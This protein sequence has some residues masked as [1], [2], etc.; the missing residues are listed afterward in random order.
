MSQE[1]RLHALDAARAFALLLGIVLHATMSFFFFV[2]AQD[3]SQSTTLAVTFYVIHV[4]R[5]GLFFLLAGFFA[6]MVLHRRGTREFLKGRAKRILVPMIVGWVLIA[7]PTIYIVIVGLTKTFGEQAAAS[8]AAMMPQGFPLTHLWFLYYLCIFYVLA[9]GVRAAFVRFVDPNGVVRSRIDTVVRLS[10][11]SYLA[12]LVLA[13]P[14][15]AVLYKDAAW[16]MWFGLPTPDIGFTPKLPALAGFGTAFVLGWLLHRQ[17]EVLEVF[18]RQCFVNLAVAIGLTSLCLSLVGLKPNMM[19]L[20]TLDGPAWSRAAYAGAYTV[21]IWYWVFGLTGAALR[22]FNKPSPGRRYIA[23]SSYWLY[24]AHLPVVFGLQV[25]L[26]DLPWHWSLKFPFIVVTTLAILLVSYHYLVRPT[27][28][29]GILNGRKYPRRSRRTGSD[30]A[31]APSASVLALHDTKPAVLEN[32]TRRFGKTVAL[33]DVTLTV[34]P[35][36]MLA[37]LGPNGAGKS[38]AISLWLGL[39]EPDEGSVRVMGASPLEVTSRLEVGVMMQDVNL[40]PDLKVREHIAQTASYYAHPLNVDEALAISGTTPLA[41]KRYGKL[42]G[43]QKRQV[44]FAVAIC[45]APKLLFLDEPTVG[46]DIEAREAMWRAIAKLMAEGSSIVLTTHYLEEAEALADR[47]A[48]LAKGK[49]VATGSVEDMR[50][51]VTRRRIS[52][53]SGVDIDEIRGWPGVVEALRDAGNVKVTAFDAESIVRRLLVADP[54]LSH[55]EVRQASLAEAF[56]ELTK[57]AA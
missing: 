7:P 25:L 48:V 3:P 37:V 54:A 16:M 13:A 34:E 26:L 43:G 41:G 28:I 17:V 20:T 55:L 40:A 31:P 49:L 35:G 22:F 8:G 57:E 23:D 29:G 51:L 5:M 50:S 24:L 4:F 39:L 14:L 47:V 11:A 10:L 56:T 9:L 1:N 2:P 36:E 32:V 38:T 52:C 21:S 15:F 12:P 27:F 30:T 45:G 44:Q 42:S 19:G 46:L 53:R 18:R 6:H 33:D